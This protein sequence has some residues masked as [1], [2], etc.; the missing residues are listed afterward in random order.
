MLHTV[1]TTFLSCEFHKN[2]YANFAKTILLEKTFVVLEA[3]LSSRI[4]L[5]I[6]LL[7]ILTVEHIHLWTPLM[8]GNIWCF[9]QNEL[10]FC[11]CIRY[12]CHSTNKMPEYWQPSRIV[13]SLSVFLPKDVKWRHD[14]T[15][16]QHMTSPPKTNNG[17]WWQ[18]QYRSFGFVRQTVQ[19][20]RHTHRDGTNFIPSTADAGGKDSCWMSPHISCKRHTIGKVTGSAAEV[21]RTRWVEENMLM[22]LPERIVLWTGQWFFSFHHNSLKLNYPR[23]HAAWSWKDMGMEKAWI[24]ATTLCCILYRVGFEYYL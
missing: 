24:S 20:H 1:L 21:T 16:W 6:K 7:R 17:L 19:T 11:V 3:C 18:T 9:T 12:Y 15:S 14:V 5:V 10:I 8:L 2:H 23:L 4:T 22:Q 13:A